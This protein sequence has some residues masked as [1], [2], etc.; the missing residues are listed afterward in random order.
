VYVDDFDGGSGERR[1]GYAGGEQQRAF[2]FGS[3]AVFVCEL[4][5]ERDVFL[6]GADEFYLESTKSYHSKRNDG[7]R[8]FLFRLCNA[9]RLYVRVG[10]YDGDYQPD[11]RYAL[12]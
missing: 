1:A 5:T 7:K 10:E 11:S 2:V 4:D 6:D 3:D 8:G 12:Y 9:Q